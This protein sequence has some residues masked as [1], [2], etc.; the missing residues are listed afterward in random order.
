MRFEVITDHPVALDSPDHI[1]PRGAQFDNSRNPVFNRRLIE[2]NGGQAAV[3]DLGCAGGGMV[4]SF[5]EMGQ[6]AVG[7][8]GSDYPQIHGLHEWPRCASLFT[9][10]ARKPF[11]VS[12]RGGG[13]FIFDAVTAWDF[14]EHIGEDD[15]P[16]VIDNIQRHLKPGGRLIC[17]VSDKPAFWEV[18]HHLTR[19]PR[20]WW[21]AFFKAHGFRWDGETVRRLGNDWV[22]DGQYKLAFRKAE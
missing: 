9:A 16:G 20:K 5:I 11:T 18:E 22:R 4:M 8:E 12:V 6:I 17:T 10:D 1:V 2:L 13:P 3:L 21:I 15:L 14:F 19:R 7:I